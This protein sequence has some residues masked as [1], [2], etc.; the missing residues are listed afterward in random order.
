MRKYEEVRKD[1]EILFNEAPASDMTGGYV[2]QMDLEKMLRNPTKRMATDCMIRQIEYW[3][4]SG[5][6]TDDPI[7]DRDRLIESDEAIRN[8]AKKYGYA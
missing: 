2:D 8:V 7:G 6:E 1:W 3:F 5:V 4:E